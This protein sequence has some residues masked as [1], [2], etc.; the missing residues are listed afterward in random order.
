MRYSST[1]LKHNRAVVFYQLKEYEKAWD[2]VRK[3]Q[4]IGATVNPEIIQMLK[5]ATGEDQ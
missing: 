3:V 5:E 2:D 4:K 1:V